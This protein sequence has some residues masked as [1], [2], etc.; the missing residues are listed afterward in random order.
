MPDNVHIVTR[1]ADIYYTLGGADNYNYA[2]KYYSFV[3]QVMPGNMR[4]MWGL[5]NTL[6]AIHS[7]KKEN[8][9]DKKLLV[10]VQSKIEGVYSGKM[11]DYIH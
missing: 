8:D 7:L 11:A 6:K 3:L 9:T 10:A 2:K 4:A 5:R 1:I